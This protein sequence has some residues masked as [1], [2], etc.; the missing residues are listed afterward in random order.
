MV[1]GLHG[2]YTL[3]KFGSEGVL[4]AAVALTSVFSEDTVLDWAWRLPFLFGALIGITAI[5]IRRRLPDSDHFRRH[6]RERAETSPL[7]EAFTRNLPATLR[8]TLF[9][10]VYGI[11]FYFALVYLP[12]WAHEQAG[13]DLDVA[14]RINATATALLLVLIPAA[15]WL[16][17]TLLRRTR[18][19]G[20]SMLATAV[21]AWP[22][23]RLMSETGS[24]WVLAAGQFVLAGLVAL[25]LGAA[26]AM[27]VEMFPA[28]D[29]LSGY[30]VSY[31]LG[32]GVMGGSTPMI[33]TGLIKWTGLATAAGVM[34]AAAGTVGVAAMMIVKDRSRE[35]LR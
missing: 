7:R 1:L 27:F 17:D 25:P 22:L 6:H 4:G 13:Y 10:S 28:R 29:R 21:V 24:L 23:F 34:L 16:S 14:M 33:A 30:S 11:V 32:L 12:T 5:L 35:A 19:I 26:P 15:G 2:Y 20:L 3:V 9:A 8:A 31:N 18:L